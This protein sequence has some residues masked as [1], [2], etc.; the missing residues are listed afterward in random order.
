MHVLDMQQDRQAAMV[1]NVA[2]K[3]PCDEQTRKVWRQGGQKASTADFCKSGGAAEQAVKALMPCMQKWA[4]ALQVI[5][6][7]DQLGT[8]PR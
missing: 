3:T 4:D 6:S 5:S 1:H 7:F 8:L 2:I